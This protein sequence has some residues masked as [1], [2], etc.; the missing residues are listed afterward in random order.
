LLMVETETE[1]KTKK[2]SKNKELIQ[3][4]RDIIIT[5]SLV[6]ANKTSSTVSY[7]KPIISNMTLD[8]ETLPVYAQNKWV[9]DEDELTESN[10][11]T[12]PTFAKLSAPKN[13]S[14]DVVIPD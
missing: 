3:A 7:P 10:L 14:R 8:R 2:K 11:K 13:M 12:A 9:G 4:N 5:T 6:E 1:K